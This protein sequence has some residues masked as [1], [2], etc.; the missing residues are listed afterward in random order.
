MRKPV[1]AAV[2]DDPLGSAAVGRGLVRHDDA[3][4]RVARRV[5][6]A[7]AGGEDSTSAY[8]VNRFLATV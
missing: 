8:L 4:Y 7:F 2:D 5:H 6:G 1:I 3:D